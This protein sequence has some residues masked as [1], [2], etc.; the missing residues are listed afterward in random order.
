MPGLLSGILWTEQL[1]HAHQHFYFGGAFT[2]K[3]FQRLANDL[4]G[5]YLV[6]IGFHGMTAQTGSNQQVASLYGAILA[7]YFGRNNT[8]NTHRYFGRQ[9]CINPFFCQQHTGFGGMYPH[10]Q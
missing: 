4:A 10:H 3:S 9:I 8:Y 2:I 5:F 1:F 7:A 6:G